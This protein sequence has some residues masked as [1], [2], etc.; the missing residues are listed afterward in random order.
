M[1]P[2]VGKERPPMIDKKVVFPLPLFPQIKLISPLLNDKFTSLKTIRL[3]FLSLNILVKF[4]TSNSS[5]D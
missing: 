1:S 4:L 5:L 2:V 3:L